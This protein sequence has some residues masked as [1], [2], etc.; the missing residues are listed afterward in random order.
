M[1]QIMSD[2]DYNMIEWEDLPS[3]N[4][5]VNAENL[6]YMDLGI[7]INRGGI[8]QLVDYCD[9]LHTKVQALEADKRWVNHPIALQGDWIA[10][11][12]FGGMQIGQ[13]TITTRDGFCII[14]GLIG[15]ADPWDINNVDVLLIPDDCLPTNVVMGL[16]NSNSGI[17]TLA[18]DP[19]SK[20][21]KIL[22]MAGDDPAAKMGAEGLFFQITYALLGG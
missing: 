17:L 21:M 1:G 20:M 2:E 8:I 18:I 12:D 3:T 14:S 4:T 7:K 19:V 5:P 6:R 13:P 15:G 16:G 10:M 11:P 9:D 22:Y